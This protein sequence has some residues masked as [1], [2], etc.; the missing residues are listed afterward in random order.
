MTRVMKQGDFRPMAKNREAMSDLV[1]ILDARKQDYARAEATL[2]TSC[3]TIEQ[4]AAK[5]NK[6]VSPWLKS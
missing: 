2:D 3:A 5:L 6:I 1:A 4:N